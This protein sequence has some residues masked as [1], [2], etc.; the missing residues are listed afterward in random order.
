LNQITDIKASRIPFRP[1]SSW[2]HFHIHT[3]SPPFNHISQK[4]KNSILWSS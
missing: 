2:K 3:I 1:F 4:S